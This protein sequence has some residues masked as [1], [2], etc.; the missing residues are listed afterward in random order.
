MMQS[1]QPIYTTAKVRYD[2]LIIIFVLKNPV[3]FSIFLIISKRDCGT[4]CVTMKR[5][6]K[7]NMRQ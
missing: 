4:G 6:V 2:Q 5:K 1:L 7:Y 3:N